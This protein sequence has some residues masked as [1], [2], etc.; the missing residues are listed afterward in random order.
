MFAQ[1]TDGV[2]LLTRVCVCACV[3]GGR[4]CESEF[5]DILRQMEVWV[6]GCG[7]ITPDSVAHTRSNCASYLYI[8]R[9]PYESCYLCV[10]SHLTFQNY[11]P[12]HEQ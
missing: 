1:I 2:C 8:E 11:T 12:Q 4:G 7:C 3:C 10:V 6:C 9:P 5:A